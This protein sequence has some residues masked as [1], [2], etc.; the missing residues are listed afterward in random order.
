MDYTKATREELLARIAELEGRVQ[1]TRT[2]DA[3]ARVIQAASPNPG[4]ANS[5][6]KPV[7]LNKA[8]RKRA[9]AESAKNNSNDFFDRYATRKIALRFSYEGWLY[10]GLALQKDE[11]TPLPTVESV[12]LDAL[13]QARLIK[14]DWKS[15]LVLKRSR[16]D[17]EA[18]QSDDGQSDDGNRSM[19]DVRRTRPAEIDHDS[20]DF[21]RCGRTDRG[22]SAAGQVI[23]LYVRSQLDNELGQKELGWRP[24][25]KP[26]ADKRAA[27]SHGAASTDATSSTASKQLSKDELNNIK[28]RKAAQEKMKVELPYVQLLNRVLPPSIRVSAWSPVS[29]DFDARFSCELRHYKYFFSNIPSSPLDISAMRDAASR[30]IGEHDFRNLCKVDPTKQIVN[31]RRRIISAAIDAVESQMPQADK[32]ADRKEDAMFVF[33]LRGTAFLYHQVRHIMAILFLVGTGVERPSIVDTL[34]NTGYRDEVLDAGKPLPDPSLP[35]VPA[36]PSYEMADDLPLVLWDCVFPEGSVSWRQ[37]AST[38]T[39]I[40]GHEH[41]RA[42]IEMYEYYTQHRLK[43]TISKHFLES[44]RAHAS[45]SPAAAAATASVAVPQAGSDHK[46]PQGRHIIQVGAARTLN[47]AKYVPLLSRPRSELVEEINRKWAEGQGKRRA[48]RKAAGVRVEEREEMKVD[49]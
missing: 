13:V 20:V 28:Q 26:A 2:S 15:R 31:F 46:H 10:C 14:N 47:A 17:D 41:D 22:V 39:A 3:A 19:R 1:Q 34:L 42:Q 24:A 5:S 33:N 8:A 23:S 12:L 38:I 11:V 16:D 37:D 40:D 21:G 49:V 32:Q 36:R 6:L 45:P 43:S 29:H 18:S 9:A 30:L 48:E 25:R 44:Y 4:S 35:V 7:K 27:P